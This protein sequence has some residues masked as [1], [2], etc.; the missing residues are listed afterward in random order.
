VVHFLTTE[1]QREQRNKSLRSLCLSCLG[2]A[3]FFR[4]LRNRP[5][6]S[7]RYF[8]SLTS[9]NRSTLQ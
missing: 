6:R 7:L 3:F 1:L 9:A 5:L 2:G 4:N 8:D